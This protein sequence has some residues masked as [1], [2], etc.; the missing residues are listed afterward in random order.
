MVPD[1]A[2]FQW[3]SPLVSFGTA[4]A[5]SWWL[6]HS[7]ISRLALDHPN[8]RSL[9]AA[10][11]PRIGGLAILAG[12]LAGVAVASPSWPVG[13]WVGIGMLLAVGALDDLQGVPVPW[14]L[15]AHF[16]AAGAAAMPLLLD[17]YGLAV[18]ALVV[19]A[20]VWMTNAYNFMDGSDGLAGGMTVAGFGFYGVAWWLGGSQSL[21]L[22]SFCVAAAAAAFLLFNFHPARIFMGDAGSV[23][24]GFLAAALGII[25]WQRGD[26][27]LW[28]PALVFSPFV[29]DATVTLLRRL[30]RGEKAWLAHRE[31][32]YQRLVRMGFG[33][34]NTALAEYAVM[35]AAGAAATWSI[36]QGPVLQLW[37]GAA[38]VVL[39]GVLMALV[40]RNWS[41]HQAIERDSGLP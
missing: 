36:G 38:W 39:Y 22:A 1:P 21:A 29:V 9:H 6:L 8:R 35:V 24:L 40:D 25:G 3:L 30:A 11:V 20:T 17:E 32:Y 2:R 10:P 23:P 41:R 33:H 28:F 13:L 26:W 19:L 31:H 12:T 18:T 37:V 7:R 4:L 34:R 27:P 5:G 16:V 15:L 14:R